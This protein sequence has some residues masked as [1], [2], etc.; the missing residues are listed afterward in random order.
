MWL[1]EVRG[2]MDD[3]DIQDE[4]GLPA[5]DAAINAAAH[6]GLPKFD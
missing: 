1:K 2:R 3:L 6:N 4:E 5:L